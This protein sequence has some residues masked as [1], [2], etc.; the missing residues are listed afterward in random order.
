LA[1]IVR[2]AWSEIV[3]E[4]TKRLG[5]NDATNF[6]TRIHYWIYHAYVH[7]CT[8]YHHYELDSKTQL[9]LPTTFPPKVSIS[10]V[11]PKPYVLV[12]AQLLNTA[13]TTLVRPLKGP[14]YAEGLLAALRITAGSP[15]TWTRYGTDFWVDQTADAAYK[16]DLYYYALPAEPDFASSSTYPAFSAD[17]DEALIQAAVALGKG[18]ITMP[19]VERELL[20]DWL[21]QQPRASTLEEPAPR[22]EKSG[23]GRSL[24]GG[25]A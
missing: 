19:G 21:A 17:C 12:S 7:L 5:G 18:S 15:T 24:G 3:T 20:S 9:T 23:A 1:A 16:V 14:A 2:R 6:S 11:T 22:K 25:Q 4:V 8:Q 10:A 13:G